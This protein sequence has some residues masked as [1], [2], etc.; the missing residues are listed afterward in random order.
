MLFKTSKRKEMMALAELHYIHGI[1]F[2]FSVTMSY[3][4]IQRKLQRLRRKSLPCKQDTQNPYRIKRHIAPVPPKGYH[5]VSI[6]R[7]R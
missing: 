2:P 1:D 5:I 6:W 3:N 7:Q 4:A